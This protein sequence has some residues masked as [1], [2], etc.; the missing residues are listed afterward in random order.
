M[1]KAL[2]FLICIFPV[3]VWGITNMKANGETELT[4]TS[5]PAL[6]EITADLSRIGA[7]LRG[8]VYAD[9]NTNNIFDPVDY[10]WNWRFGYTIDGVGWIKDP[11]N[12]LASILGDEGA[13]DGKLRVIFPLLRQQVKLWPR[14]TIFIFMQ[15]EDGSSG[16]IR[17]HLDIKTSAP[18]I[19][20]KVTSAATGAPI[21]DLALMAMR[22]SGNQ[23]FDFV[24]GRTDAEGNYALLADVGNWTVYADGAGEGTGAYMPAHSGP[25]SLGSSEILVRNIALTPFSALLKGR[26][27]HE[28]GTPVPQVL[29]YATGA[30]YLVART[31]EEGRYIMGTEPGFTQIGL[32]H[33]MLANYMHLSQYYEEKPFVNVIATAGENTGLDFVLKKYTSFIRGRCTVEGRGVMGAEVTAVFTDPATGNGRTSSCLSDA[34]GH[35]LIGVMPGT[36]A[37]LNITANGLDAVEPAG[38]RLNLAAAANDTLKG[39]DWEF[40][41]RQGRNSISGTVVGPAGTPAEG[42]CVVAVE[43]N[44]LYYDSYF[45]QFTNARGEFN[46]A[47]L[48][49][50]EWRVG[51]YKKGASVSPAMIYHSLLGGQNIEGARFTLSGFTGISGKS[52]APQGFTLEQ[53][54][55]NPFNGATSIHFTLAHPGDVSLFIRDL[56]GREVR[57]IDRP[58]LSAGARQIHWDGRDDRGGELPSGIYFYTL[59]A[60]GETAQARMLMVR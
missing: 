51:V 8:G 7:V 46:F 9:I 53:N 24:N 57:R 50:G 36:V 15:D 23:T 5:V 60:D 44:T 48:K 39:M 27:V 12:P 30:G 32:A 28:D 16:V 41:I 13:P 22:D 4:I 56:L 55:P 11:A 10:S 21:A 20:G 52:G 19:I 47:G 29:L 43:A 45:F 42:V 34:D 35:Y 33:N 17:L 18:A 31:D 1:K 14:G 26:V 54:Y 59:E 6:L 25:L 58:G 3:T 49:N 38:M 40:R 2:L 37:S